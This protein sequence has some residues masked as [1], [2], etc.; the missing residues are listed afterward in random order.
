[1][2]SYK[3]PADPFSEYAAGHFALSLAVLRFMADQLTALE[4]KPA[5]A[6]PTALGLDVSLQQVAGSSMQLACRALDDAIRV[7][8]N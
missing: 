3:A 1:M 7:F 6:S 2:D 8:T 4:Q 5:S